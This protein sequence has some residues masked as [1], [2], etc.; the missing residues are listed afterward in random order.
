[1][2][3]AGSATATSVRSGCFERSRPRPDSAARTPSESASTA[4]DIALSPRDQTLSAPE[5]DD[6]LIIHNDVDLPLE[7][8][9]ILAKDPLVDD[10]QQV[11]IHQA[12]ADRWSHLITT[13][14]PT[15]EA[16][17]LEQRYKVPINCPLLT[18]PELNVETKLLI[19]PNIIKKT[20]LM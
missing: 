5:Q 20:R 6:A 7:V 15:N 11:N 3:P 1:M 12:L 9:N 14:L 10:S 8:L 2:S 17:A 13:G 16:E 19:P 18:P 4:R